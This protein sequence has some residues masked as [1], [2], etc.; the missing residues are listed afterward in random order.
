[1]RGEITTH[2]GVYELAGRLAERQREQASSLRAR[3]E[4]WSGAWV[5]AAVTSESR[6]AADRLA[7]RRAMAAMHFGELREGVWTR[8]DNLPLDEHARVMARQCSVW[9]AR[10]DDDPVMLARTLFAPEQWAK[11]ALRLRRELETVIAGLA[12]G[13]AGLE[14]H[15]FVAGAAA[16]RHVR[17]DPLLPAE[18]LPPDWPGDALRAAYRKYRDAFGDAA[19]EWFTRQRAA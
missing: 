1:V 13:D 3:R 10:P 7:L 4:K 8:P 5:L 9:R 16:L 15:G 17:A 6:D 19:T 2:D 12:Q 14:P 11:R 18:L